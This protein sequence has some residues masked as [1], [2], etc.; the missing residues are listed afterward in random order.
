MSR[1]LTT[2]AD[3]VPDTEAEPAVPDRFSVYDA[4]TA[5]WVVRRIVEA[6]TYARRAKQWAQDEERRAQ[7]E[8]EFFLTRFGPELRRWLDR[9]LATRGGKE[10][11]ITL[12]AGRVG[13]R[14]IG[15]KIEV[16]DLD[17]V[18]AWAK[19]HCPD[20][21]KQSESLLKTPLTNHFQATGELPDGTTLEPE[22]DELYVR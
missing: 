3:Q 16:I 17:T 19:T 2:A 5:N 11:S 20:A 1:D 13:R 7:R 4:K 14:Q 10:K 21:I 22:R 6:R 18:L 15:P 8:V 12:P 9:E